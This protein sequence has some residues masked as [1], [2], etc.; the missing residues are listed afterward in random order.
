MAASA[1]PREETAA[2]ALLVIL[3]DPTAYLERNGLVETRRAPTARLDLRANPVNQLPLAPPLPQ[4]DIVR[5]A[6]R[7]ADPDAA[8]SLVWPPGD[9]V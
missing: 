7:P 3:N 6:A 5:R 4:P 2:M 9:A 8:A 1:I